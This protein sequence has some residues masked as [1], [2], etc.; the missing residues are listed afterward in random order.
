MIIERNIFQLKFGASKGAL[1][2]WKSYLQKVQQ[3]DPDVHVRILTDISGPAYVL[4]VELRHQTFSEAEP[5]QCRL[6]QRSDWRE[7]Y[8]QFIPFCEKSERAYYK[9]LLEF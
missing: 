4:V 9:L 1:D 6:V 2:L 7:F 8:Q 5:S 3:E